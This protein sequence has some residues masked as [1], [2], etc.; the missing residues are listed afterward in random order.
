MVCPILRVA[1]QISLHNSKHFFGEFLI[2]N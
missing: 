1:A 2:L